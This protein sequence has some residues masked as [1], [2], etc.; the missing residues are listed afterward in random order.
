MAWE[1]ISRKPAVMPLSLRI[2]RSA[3]DD[4]NYWLVG[5]DDSESPCYLTS[6][7]RND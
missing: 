6:A 7:E 1:G 5:E 4:S 3:R 2:I